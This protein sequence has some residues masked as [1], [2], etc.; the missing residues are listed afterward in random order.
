MEVDLSI[1]ILQN[2]RKEP[3]GGGG[4]GEATRFPGIGHGPLIQACL[5]HVLCIT[6]RCTMPLR[7]E[8]RALCLAQ[9]APWVVLGDC[10]S[11]HPGNHHRGVSCL[12]VELVL[13]SRFSSLSANLSNYSKQHRPTPGP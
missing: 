11:F 12:G 6:P 13:D 1:L 8:E 7:A 5:A 3:R 2:Q 9:E 4:G 10:E